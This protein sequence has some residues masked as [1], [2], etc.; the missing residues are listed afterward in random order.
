MSAESL[1][2]A[3]RYASRLATRGA[4][5]VALMDADGVGTAIV[6]VAIGDGV[7]HAVEVLDDHIVTTSWRTP[8]Q[9]REEFDA[10]LLAGHVVEAWREARLLADPHGLAASLQHHARQWDWGRIAGQCDRAVASILTTTAGSV[11]ELIAL[12]ALGE[13]RALAAVRG[14]LASE[15]AA[16]MVVHLRL[17]YP[18][19]HDRWDVVAAA[20]GPD[21]ERDFDLALGVGRAA[22]DFAALALYRSATA[23]AQRVLSP[24]QRDVVDAAVRATEHM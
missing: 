4:H 14:T 10:P 6:L 16:A 24:R 21:W 7:D 23:R 12:R 5:A 9:V 13:R 15:C 18:R 8:A 19:A 2:I 17:L 1:A 11:Q 3:Q 20:M 22:D